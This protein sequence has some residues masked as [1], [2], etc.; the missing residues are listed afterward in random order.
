VA[1]VL[2]AVAVPAFRDFIRN[3]RMSAQMNE[4]VTAL[5]LARSEAIKRGQRVT[6][7]KSANAEDASPACDTRTNGWEQ[8]WLVFAE[9]PA[10]PARFGLFDG[11]DALIR[12]HDG[13]GEGTTLRGNALVRNNVSYQ[14]DGTSRTP[15]GA[16]QAGT[17]TLCDPRGAEHARAVILSFT[18]RLRQ[19]RDEDHDGV[20][21]G[22]DAQN[23]SCGS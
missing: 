19:A 22:G 3:S 13:F 4:F 12:Q 23:V 9:D 1:A 6:V 11:Q 17:L 8:G 20:V 5:T 7:C 15:N 14:A 16:T 18:G 2:I 10:Q 21:E